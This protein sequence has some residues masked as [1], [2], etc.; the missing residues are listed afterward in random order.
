MAAGDDVHRGELRAAVGG[1]HLRD[2]RLRGLARHRV[3]AAAG[4][5]G[6]GHALG[7]VLE[8]HAPQAGAVAQ[9]GQLARRP[10]AVDQRHK[11]IGRVPCR[12]SFRVSNQG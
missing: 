10:L 5:G 11:V 2:V 12:R 9:R 1:V 7:D 4:C 8:R 3:V 6:H